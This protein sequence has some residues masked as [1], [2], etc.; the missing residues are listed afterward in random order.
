MQYI[1]DGWRKEG[2]IDANLVAP[3]KLLDDLVAKGNFGRK[4]GQG[5]YSY[6]GVGGKK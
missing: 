3:V 2:K 5:F 6:S 1:V 4:S